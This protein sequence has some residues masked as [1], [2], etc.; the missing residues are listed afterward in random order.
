MILGRYLR[1]IILHYN[2]DVI[3]EDELYEE[4]RLL[5]LECE[6]K[7]QSPRKSEV[8]TD[9]KVDFPSS[10]EDANVPTQSPCADETPQKSPAKLMPE[11]EQ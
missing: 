1:I 3:D 8:I 5:E 10:K 9:E 4:F 11:P 7:S 2:S 6:N